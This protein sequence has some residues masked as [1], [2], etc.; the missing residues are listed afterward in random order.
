MGAGVWI[1]PPGALGH[2]IEL[3]LRMMEEHE[4]TSH[5]MEKKY[6]N[7]EQNSYTHECD[8]VLVANVHKTEVSVQIRMNTEQ[9]PR[10]Q[11]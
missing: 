10:A 9:R 6:V 5:L 4:G 1:A 11:R 3:R 7:L 8:S 2:M